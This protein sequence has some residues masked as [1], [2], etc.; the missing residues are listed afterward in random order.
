M[1]CLLSVSFDYDFYPLLVIVGIAWLIPMLMSVF[2]LNKVPAVIIE[3]ITGFFI[4][5]YLLQSYSV[6]DLVIVDFLA[7]TG[8][9]FL[10]FLGGL[11]INV[12]QIITSFPRRK[13]NYS[14]FIKNPF[15][16]GIL[17]FILT[18]GLSYAASFFISGITV[19]ENKWYFALIM[20]TTSVGIILPVLKNRG[21]I[22]TLYGQMI[23]LSS[24]VA[25]VLS[26]LLFTI[27]AFLLKEGLGFEMLW[28]FLLLAI[29][30]IF[31]FAGTFL[32][33]FDL[34]VKITHKLSHA[35]SQIKVRG[36][37]LLILIFVVA[38]G[39]IGTEVILLGA[40]LGG[41][42]LSFFLHKDRSLLLIKLDGMGYG[43]FIP[44]FF[45][46]VG[47]TFEPAHLLALDQSLL[48]FLLVLLLTLFA[49]K[50]IPSLIWTRL[51]GLRKAVA[52]GF[53]IS[54]RLS[55]IIAAST[56]GVE[57]D[58]ISHG[59]N[60]CFIVMAVLTCLFSP[61]IFNFINP[62]EK[63]PADKTVI[64]GGSSTAV[65]L[66]RRLYMHNR[67]VIIIDKK[68]ERSK[69]INSKGIPCIYGDGRNQSIYDKINLKPWNYIVILTD[70][71]HLNIE[72][73]RIVRQ[74]L[75]HER[76]ITKANKRW[77]QRALNNFEVEYFDAT[78]VIATTIESLILRP[79]V[80]HTFVESFEN[81]SLEEIKLTARELDGLSISDIPVH[82]DATIIL[83][84]RANEMYIPHGDTYLRMGDVLNILGTPTALEH[85][86]ELLT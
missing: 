67:E 9:I 64:I 32:R 83:I 2:R 71:D 22:N 44:V 34:Y 20:I 79:T 52:G 28:L 59:I 58:V 13:L 68:L 55:L 46:V 78:R 21:E 18:L 70:D 30:L 66:A 1:F 29:F 5:K 14:R 11:E 25:D 35:A 6:E 26:I 4:G 75:N 62:P 16:V 61:L 76:V 82:R 49:V 63:I 3:I 72:I 27:T 56:I 8:F 85:S 33:K 42:L 12:D 38:S 57:L 86:R 50:V 19:I 17:I 80:Y 15:L 77:I 60:A 48:T 39:F 45:I 51:F 10:M 69:E 41:L 54:S 74:E 65:L 40:F 43:F 31:Y 36:T 37:I 47:I 84:R 53:L 81:F 23:I 73:S 24:A 7:L